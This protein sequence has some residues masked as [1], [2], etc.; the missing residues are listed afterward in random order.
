MSDLREAAEMALEVLSHS[1][2]HSNEA[3]EQI[4]KTKQALRQALAESANSTTNLVEPKAS[5]QPEQEPTHEIYAVLFAVEEAVRN[6][7]APWD[8]EAA[9][10]KY[11]TKLK[12]I[13]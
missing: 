5:F 12:E 1:L 10:E 7:C 9:F 13:K 3:Q 2:G 11:E 4:D 8:I 6:G